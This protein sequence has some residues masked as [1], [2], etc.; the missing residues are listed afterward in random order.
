[1]QGKLA[2]IAFCALFIGLV[3]TTSSRAVVPP[4]TCADL[5]ELNVYK[6]RFADA[7]SEVASCQVQREKATSAEAAIEL[8]YRKSYLDQ[9]LKFREVELEVY[10]WQISAANAILYLVALLTVFGIVFSGYQLWKVNRI[11]KAPPAG[12]ELELSV[13]K[14]R[15]QTSVIGAIVLFVSYAFLLVFT[16]DIYTI[17]NT[18][19]NSIKSQSSR[20]V[21]EASPTK[22]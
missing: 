21:V 13:S 4:V 8:A 11:S 2:A 19:Q 15:I 3:V 22:Q 18:D 9:E 1:M 20:P 5:S 17:R 16:R 12:V 10:H 14:L 7:K 6:T